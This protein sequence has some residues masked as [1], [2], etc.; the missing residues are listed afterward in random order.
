MGGLMNEDSM[1]RLKEDYVFF[2]EDVFICVYRKSTKLVIL[3]LKAGKGDWNAAVKE[4]LKRPHRL[5]WLSKQ[6]YWNW[7]GILLLKYQ[8]LFEELTEAETN[9]AVKKADYFSVV[10]P[11][12]F[13]ENFQVDASFV[14]TQVYLWGVTPLNK[15]LYENLKETIPEVYIVR[16]EED[17]ADENS[18]M[19]L[20]GEKQL[21]EA[22]PKD[23]IIPE[24]EMT[25]RRGIRDA[26]FLV[27]GTG[28][29]ADRLIEINDY[30]T[31]HKAVALFYNS[32]NKDTVIGPLVIGR[33]SACLRCMQNQDILTEYYPG[34]NGFIDRPTWHLFA[35]FVLRILYYIKDKNLYFLLSDAQIPI[36]K[37]MMVSRDDMTAKMKYLHR[38]VNC[39]CCK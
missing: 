36:N 22:I 2:Q 34:E 7:L 5:E 18:Y 12:H 8:D 1:I 31:D 27:D 6:P 17:L 28:M 3:K 23:R 26:L 25:D 35:F 24:K 38:D 19:G 37:V 13:A 39:P 33:E 30:V 29:N 14:Q 16:K 11:T 15:L 10:N 21:E 4:D 32:T 20:S 9:N